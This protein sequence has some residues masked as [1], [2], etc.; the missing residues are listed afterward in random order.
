[1]GLKFNRQFVIEHADITGSKSYFIADF[2]CFEKK[3]IVEIDGKV[4]EQQIEYDKIR[5][6]I[7]KEIGYNI[8]R[9][10][11]EEVINTWSEVAMRLE[12]FITR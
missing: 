4:H 11:N 8:I 1:M 7:L 12:Y 5:E 10:Q 3:L 9:F 2:H 6:D